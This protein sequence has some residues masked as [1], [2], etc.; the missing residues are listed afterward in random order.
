MQNQDPA[1][2]LDTRKT[3]KDIEFGC[4][5]SH[6]IVLSRDVIF[7]EQS[8]AATNK[9]TVNLQLYPDDQDPDA[10]E[11]VFVDAEGKLDL[12]L[13]EANDECSIKR[14]PEVQNC[15]RDRLRSN[16]TRYNSAQ[17]SSQCSILE[18]GVAF[19]AESYEPQS[20]DEA[21]QS[22]DCIQWKD[23]MEDE[24]TSLRKNE[25]WKSVGKPDNRKIVDNKWVFCV[26]KGERQYRS[27][28]SKVGGSWIFTA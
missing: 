4:H 3:P 21:I 23:A 1:F 24:M 6:K 19:I 7:E 20:F 28:Q 13:V 26:K 18:D 27:V 9:P 11:D 16:T 2:S 22:K 8:V 17:A 25:T 15:V 14:V 5:E 12:P 10:V